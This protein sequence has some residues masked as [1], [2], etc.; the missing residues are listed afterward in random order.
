MNMFDNQRNQD[1][2]R[3]Q[4]MS[5]MK[6]GSPKPNT[7]PAPE[8]KAPAAGENVVQTA[9]SLNVGGPVGAVEPIGLAE[10]LLGESASDERSPAGLRSYGA[11]ATGPEFVHMTKFDEGMRVYW[12][13]PNGEAASG[14]GTIAEIETDED[15]VMYPDTTIWVEMD[16]GRTEA[17]QAVGVELEDL[18]TRVKIALGDMID[19][20]TVSTE[21]DEKDEI[22]ERDL[23]RIASATAIYSGPN[24]DLEKL[25]SALG[26]MIELAEASIEIDQDDDVKASDMERI[27]AA[28][29]SHVADLDMS[30]F[31]DET[32]NFLPANQEEAASILE[33]LNSLKVRDREVIRRLVHFSK[34]Q[35]FAEA[36]PKII[37]EMQQEY[38]EAAHCSR[39]DL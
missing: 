35:E 2:K 10:D 36:L 22:H 24:A 32:V 23:A 19:L 31:E 16:D 9:H 5:P 11:E 12:H 25:N 30:I 13:D 1:Q 33:S 3:T 4:E 8:G 14:P 15:E 37:D 17:V 34:P 26:D 39:N 28:K 29:R 20:A 7:H 18:S 21:H 38:A 6:L 27:V